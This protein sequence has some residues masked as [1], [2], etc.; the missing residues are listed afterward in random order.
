ML[1]EIVQPNSQLI[2]GS[3]HEQLCY[4]VLVLQAIRVMVVDSIQL[5]PKLVVVLIA[6]NMGDQM[7]L[8]MI[9]LTV[10]GV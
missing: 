9:L 5:L 1:L 10:S 8:M 3:K 7:V 2:E 4:V 6:R